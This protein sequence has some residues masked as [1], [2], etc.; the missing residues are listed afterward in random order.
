M[1][2]TPASALECYVRHH[3]QLIAYL[4]RLGDC[5]AQAEDLAQD[6]WLKLA[7]VMSEQ[8]LD[9]PKAYLFHIATNLLRDACRQRSRLVEL[10]TETDGEACEQLEDPQADPCRHVECQARLHCA[11]RQLDSLPP[12]CREVFVLARL[13]G[14][15]HAQIAEQLGIAVNTVVAQLAKARQRLQ[16]H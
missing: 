9:N 15:S 13:E 3:R 1:N 10:E 7:R 12:R 2:E 11:L 14:L 8:T 5:R 16:P 4:T 6:A